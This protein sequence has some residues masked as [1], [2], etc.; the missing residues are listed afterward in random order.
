M[1]VVLDTNVLVSGMIT[2][3]GT[4]ARI[5]DLAI[6][7]FLETCVDARI[8]A[9][10]EAVLGRP[11]LDIEPVDAETL[12]EFLRSYS[13]NVVA[14]PLKVQLPDPADQPFLEVASAAGAVLVTGNSRHFPARTR[15]AV[16]VVSPREML[17]LLRS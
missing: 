15:N 3:G 10:Y 5:L 17:D 1:R 9:E 14:P 12:G 6:E 11:E 4:C 8:L 2:G 7:G 13:T 16:V